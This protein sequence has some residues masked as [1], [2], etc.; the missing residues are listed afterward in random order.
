M[1]TKHTPAPWR[2]SRADRDGAEVS[3]IA[4][5]AWCGRA[6]H[7]GLTETQV[8]DEDEARANAQLISAAPNLLV[9]LEK[10]I[11]ILEAMDRCAAT[12]LVPEEGAVLQEACDV[13]AKA[14]GEKP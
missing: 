2:V 14:K 13:V 6:S 11:A 12:R 4:S 9:A 1:T 8:I 3:A 5:V 7:V 10:C